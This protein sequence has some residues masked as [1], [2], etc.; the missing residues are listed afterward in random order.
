MSAII[1]AIDRLIE[2]NAALRKEHALAKS[3]RAL[4]KA[5][6]AAFRTQGRAFL[7][8]FAKLRT[9][10]PREIREVAEAIPWEPLFDDAELSTLQAFAQP[11]DEFTARSLL[12]GI[13]AAIAEL[14]VETSFTLEHPEAVE[15]LKQRGTERLTQIN[16]TTRERL[17]LILEQA[18]EEGWSYNK[19][20]KAIQEQFK[21]FSK[22]RAKNIAVFELG[23]AYE[24]GN[25]LVAKDLQSG[26]L[27]MQKNWLSVGDDRVRPDHRANQ[28]Q[29]WI[30]LDDA[31]Q[32][33]SD[34][35]PSDPRCRCTLLM[36]RKPEA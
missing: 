30:P 4:A 9:R 14:T 24:Y 17:R 25:M 16:G 20:A 36:R 7:K 8:R 2:A 33:G 6:D 15:Y 34:R 28:G 32:D 21:T 3:E 31:F 29:G 23:D 10:F 19:T 27:E 5:I 35:P 22:Q 26:G 18:G 12:S 1:D 11:L 13:T